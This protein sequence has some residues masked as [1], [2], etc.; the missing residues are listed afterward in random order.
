[1]SDFRR[2]LGQSGEQMAVDFLEQEGYSIVTR[3]F[4][5]KTGEID[6][7]AR[8]KDYLVIVEVK[9]RR[10]KKYGEP[11]ASVDFHKQRQ[12]CKATQYYLQRHELFE[13]DIRFDVIAIVAPD[14][15]AP[16][17]QHIINA[18]DYCG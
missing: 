2:Q 16:T 7:I 14:N 17:I 5:C 1:M 3:N 18:F 4:R 10:N 9:T 13:Q 15:T 6:I 11:A 8:D 12:I